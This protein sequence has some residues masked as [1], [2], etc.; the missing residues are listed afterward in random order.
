[1]KDIYPRNYKIR[2]TLELEQTNFQVICTI[3]LDSSKPIDK[4][5]LNYDQLVISKCLL[6]KGDIEEV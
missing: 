5:K 1:M 4:I 3:E 2:L 6:K